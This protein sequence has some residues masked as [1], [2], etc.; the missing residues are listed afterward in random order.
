M[1]SY[2]SQKTIAFYSNDESRLAKKAEVVLK[3]ISE[4]ELSEKEL[5]AYQKMLS[6]KSKK[7]ARIKIM[8]SGAYDREG[9]LLPLFSES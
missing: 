8:L 6:S 7:Q 3:T 1:K 4:L 2:N 9:Q 5:K